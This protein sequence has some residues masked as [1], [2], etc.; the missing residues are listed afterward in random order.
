M[1]SRLERNAYRPFVVAAALLFPCA[2]FFLA[3]N[4]EVEETR[5]S[6]GGISLDTP[7]GISAPFPD[8]QPAEI[9]LRVH[10]NECYS[11]SCHE[12]IETTCDII[13]EGSGRVEVAAEF[14]VLVTDGN[15]WRPGGAC[16]S[17]CARVSADCGLIDRPDDLLVVFGQRGERF[18]AEFPLELPWYS[19]W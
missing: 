2:T 7:D 8:F 1:T 3:C 13:S 11:G 18:E 16:T 12:V 5:T 15:G 10:G 6:L 4:H 9:R 19:E 17:D 14:R